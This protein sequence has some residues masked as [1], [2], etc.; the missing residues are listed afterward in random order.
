LSPT[1]V[2]VPIGVAAFIGTALLARESHAEKRSGVDL[3]GTSLVTAVWSC[4]S[5]RSSR[6]A[7]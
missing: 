1:E 6:V 4:C 3:G 7:P 5:T 2:N